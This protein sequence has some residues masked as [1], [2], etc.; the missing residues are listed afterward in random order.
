[1]RIPIVS[2][3]LLS[4]AL[5][6]AT[7]RAQQPAAPP[8]HL[9]IALTYDATRTN[10]T[11]GSSFWLQGGGAELA[12]ILPHGLGVVA[13]V[14]GLHSG[15]ISSSQL[16]LSLVTMTFG[17]RYTRQ[18][19]P[20]PGKGN[21]SVFGEAL[22]GEAFGFDSLFPA[23]GTV[24]TDAHSLALEM[25]G[26]VDLGLTRHVALRLA[27]LDWLRT[28]LPNDDSN[29]QNHLSINAGVAFHF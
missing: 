7:A 12:G 20:R 21:L 10:V 4:A 19:R 15:D 14:A 3:L 25:G 17:P 9:D 26:G 5:F 1:M 22:A 6:T 2:L 11:N 24:A 28:Q 27:Q 29:V 13:R 8:S 18:V 16:P 23:G